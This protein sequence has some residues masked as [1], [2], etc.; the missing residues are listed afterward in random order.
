MNPLIGKRKSQLPR[1]LS[2]NLPYQ[3]IVLMLKSPKEEEK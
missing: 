3:S 1:L 2:I